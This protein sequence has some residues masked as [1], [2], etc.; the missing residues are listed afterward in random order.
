M[1]SSPLAIACQ[2]SKHGGGGCQV[3]PGL[4]TLNQLKKIGIRH[5]VDLEEDGLGAGQHGIGGD[6]LKEHLS[7]LTGGVV[8]HVLIHEIYVG[9]RV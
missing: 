7:E 4:E 8:H 6:I 5:G 9:V 2:R 3:R 1:P